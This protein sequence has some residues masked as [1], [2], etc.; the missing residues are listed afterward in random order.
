MF[1][2]YNGLFIFYNNW[3]EK[4]NSVIVFVQIMLPWF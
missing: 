2:S 3:I 4:N 1:F